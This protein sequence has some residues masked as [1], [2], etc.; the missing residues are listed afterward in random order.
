MSLTTDQLWSNIVS[1]LR[2]DEYRLFIRSCVIDV[3]NDPT[4]TYLHDEFSPVV[5]ALNAVALEV[6]NTPTNDNLAAAVTE[7]KAHI[8]DVCGPA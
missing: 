4:H 8:D 2:G 7:I 3:L 1:Y 5:D 6:D